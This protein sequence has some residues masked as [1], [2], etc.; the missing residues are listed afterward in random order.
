[1]KRFVVYALTVLCLVVAGQVSAGTL[2]DPICQDAAR[3]GWNHPGKN[4][5]CLM[6]ILTGL[7]N[8]GGWESRDF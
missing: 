1:M 8:D 4:H 5:G 3:A 7:F 6:V 2:D